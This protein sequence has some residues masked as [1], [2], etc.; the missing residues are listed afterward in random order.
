M[1]KLYVWTDVLKNYRTG[2]MFAYAH[3]VDEA[4]TMLVDKFFDNGTF[5]SFYQSTLDDIMKEP[6]VYTTPHADFMP[7]SD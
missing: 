1:L 7:G 5:D 3:D 2:V 4:R 6:T